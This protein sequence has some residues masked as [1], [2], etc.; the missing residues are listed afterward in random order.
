MKIIL[1]GGFLG[2]GKTTFIRH[3]AEFLVKQEGKRVVIIE[4]EAG[5]VGIDDKLLSLD[6]FQVKEI[7]GGC[8]CCQ[9]TAELTVA[10]GQIMKQFNPQWI[11]VE[12]TGLAKIASVIDTLKKYGKGFESVYTIVLADAER[13]Q[14]LAEIMPDFVFSQV[15]AADLVLVNKIDQAPAVDLTSII[16]KIKEVNP[17]ARVE[18]VSALNG[19]DE[20]LFKGLIRDE[21]GSTPTNP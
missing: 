4:N 6:G 20:K 13:W 17:Q 3:L 2:S 8:I 11:I 12:A 19:I 15:A 14:E 1:T 5:E 18:S 10:V 21:S 16:S 7:S 9:L